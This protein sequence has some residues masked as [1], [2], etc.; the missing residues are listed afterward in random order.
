MLNGVR[1]GAS[2]LA[3]T[4]YLLHGSGCAEQEA[5]VYYIAGNQSVDESS[6]CE[7]QLGGQSAFRAAGTL[8][9]SMSNIYVLFP[10]IESGIPKTEE[11]TGKGPPEL[12]ADNS[13]VLIK[14]AIMV[15]RWTPLSSRN[16]G[17]NRGDIAAGQICVFGRKCRGKP[18]K[19]TIA[20][21]EV[22]TSDVGQLLQQA[23]LIMGEPYQSAELL[24][25]VVLEGQLQ[26]GTVVY[27]NEFTYPITVCN[28]CL[29]YFPVP[30][31]T[32]LTLE[33]EPVAPCF[34]GQ[35]DAIDCRICYILADSDADAQKCLNQN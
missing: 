6:N 25:S 18:N 8:D 9:L 14:G 7:L 10:L 33:P 12:L 30:D 16:S 17:A 29:L 22:I 26:D 3:I 2:A 31:C 15:K 32:D 13:T 24:V 11:V 5:Q 34:P 28:Q 27:S 4:L 23:Q 1:I 35:D 20:S 21:I 19:N